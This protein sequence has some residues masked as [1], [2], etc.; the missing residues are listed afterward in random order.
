VWESDLGGE[1]GDADSFLIYVDGGAERLWHVGCQNE[2]LSPLAGP[3]R[4]RWQRVDEMPNADSDCVLEPL[5]LELGAGAHELVIRNREDAPTEAEAV[6]LARLVVT[7]DP[8]WMPAR[9]TGSADGRR[10][11]PASFPE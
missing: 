9:R 3:G 10:A 6:R 4:W 2:V 1:R 11:T 5:V 7:D 8:D